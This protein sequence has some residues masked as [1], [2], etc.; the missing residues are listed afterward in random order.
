MSGM[1]CW[2]TTEP[3]NTRQV[4]LVSSSD[5]YYKYWDGKDFDAI[6]SAFI[7]WA[8]I[9]FWKCLFLIVAW[10]SWVVLLTCHS[11]QL[12]LCGIVPC[13][14]GGWHHWRAP[15]EMTQKYLEH[16]SS[17]V[18][19]QNCE[20]LPI[21]KNC[22]RSMQRIRYSFV[23]KKRCRDLVRV[24]HLT[25]EDSIL[26]KRKP[27]PLPPYLSSSPCNNTSYEKFSHNSSQNYTRPPIYELHPS[28]T[29][30]VIVFQNNVNS[31]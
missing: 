15:N 26:V 9:D 23:K 2:W 12:V 14:S 31:S 10:E 17:A 1:P 21:N 30:A 6:C 13:T 24:V 8:W 20:K 3:A 5:F 7:K 11:S 27:Y 29:R 16:H 22:W 19:P 28:P 4:H 18:T 25:N